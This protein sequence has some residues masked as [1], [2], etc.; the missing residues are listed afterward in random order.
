MSDI[1]VHTYTWK[2]V[3]AY[4]EQKYQE[5]LKYYNETTLTV[6]EILKTIGLCERNRTA[7]YIRQRLRKEGHNGVKRYILIRKGEWL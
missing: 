1:K 2:E 7:T 3:E 6:A 5:F 4:K